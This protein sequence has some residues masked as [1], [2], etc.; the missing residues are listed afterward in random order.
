MGLVTDDLTSLLTDPKEETQENPFGFSYTSPL[1]THVE[2]GWRHAVYRLRK[3]LRTTLTNHG[4][5]GDGLMR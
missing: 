4:E 1:Q 2:S 5:H 3:W